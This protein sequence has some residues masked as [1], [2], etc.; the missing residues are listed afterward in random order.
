[1]FLNASTSIWNSLEGNDELVFC[2]F[3]I[4]IIEI[5]SNKY[6]IMNSILK[7]DVNFV[8]NASIKAQKFAFHI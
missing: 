4:I 8:T 1:M 2:P 6:A 7:F 3:L 5:Q